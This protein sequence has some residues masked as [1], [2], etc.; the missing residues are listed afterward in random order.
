MKNFPEYTDKQL[1]FN[2][3]KDFCHIVMP[4]TFKFTTERIDASGRTNLVDFDSGNFCW[5]I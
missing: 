2:Q 1:S 4:N 5:I 3:G